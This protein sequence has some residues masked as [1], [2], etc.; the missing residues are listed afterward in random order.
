M[1]DHTVTCST[2]QWLPDNHSAIRSA[3]VVVRARRRRVGICRDDACAC[4]A[5]QLKS[6]SARAR[7]HM[8]L[9]CGHFLRARMPRLLRNANFEFNG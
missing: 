7:N 5:V 8:Q 3:R 9:G 1:P 6:R 4:S 2:I